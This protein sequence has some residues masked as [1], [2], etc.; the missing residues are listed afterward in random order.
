MR[1]PSVSDY[2]SITIQ[3]SEQYK[4]CLKPDLLHWVLERYYSWQEFHE[5]YKMCL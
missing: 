4:K 3:S 2:Q 5:R 1:I